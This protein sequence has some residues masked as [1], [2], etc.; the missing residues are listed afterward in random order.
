MSEVV[1]RTDG[2]WITNLPG[3]FGD[4]GPY[5][6][7]ADAQEDERGLER[8]YK[9]HQKYWDKLNKTLGS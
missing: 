1:K 9:R 4:H 7:K 6:R 2:Y 5:D 8:T 3:G